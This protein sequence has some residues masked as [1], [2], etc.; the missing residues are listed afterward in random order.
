MHLR[1]T[2]RATLLSPQS[3]PATHKVVSLNLYA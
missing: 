2:P 1:G 3:S